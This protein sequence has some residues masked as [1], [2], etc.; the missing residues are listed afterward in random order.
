VIW[1]VKVRLAA[2]MLRVL[3]P[4]Y[5]KMYNVHYMYAAFGRGE[6]NAQC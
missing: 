2:E 3:H 5:A 6:E 4:F 1:A